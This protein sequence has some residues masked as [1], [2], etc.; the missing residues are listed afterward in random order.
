MRTLCARRCPLSPVR[1]LV[2]DYQKPYRQAM[3]SVVEATDGFVVAGVVETGEDSLIA[4]AETDADLVLMDVNL[5]GID[6]IEAARRLCAPGGRPAVI[7]LSTA[8]QSAETVRGCGDVAFIPKEDFG[9]DRLEDT[10][11]A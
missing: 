4:A 11:A 3:I 9:P 10:W 7:L 2:V 5:P 6:G 8:E 1:V